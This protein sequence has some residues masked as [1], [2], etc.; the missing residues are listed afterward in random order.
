MTG[1]RFLTR[2]VHEAIV[3]ANELGFG[4]LLV[5]GGATVASAFIAADLADEI[6]CYQ[7][8]LMIGAGSSS[9]NMPSTSTLSEARRFRLDSA[10]RESLTRLGDDIALHLEPLPRG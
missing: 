9:V 2:D 6:Y 7:A 8:P 4:H 3:R 1:S 10:S 5:E